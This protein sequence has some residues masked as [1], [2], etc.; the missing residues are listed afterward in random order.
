MGEVATDGEDQMVRTDIVD[1]TEGRYRTADL[2]YA[3]YLKVAEVPFIETVREGDRVYFIFKATDGLRE[4]KNGF[5]NRT[6]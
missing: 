6:I 3:A 5:Y 4:L 1:E 2:Y